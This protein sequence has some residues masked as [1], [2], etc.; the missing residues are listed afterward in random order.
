MTEQD[1]DRLVLENA[2][3]FPWLRF[4]IAVTL[5]VWPV[6]YIFHFL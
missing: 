6:I 3:S 5:S 2:D 1:Q 4:V